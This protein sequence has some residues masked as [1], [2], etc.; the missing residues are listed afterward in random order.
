[1]D[2]KRLIKY[3]V[4]TF[5]ITWSCWWG[6]AFLL[7]ISPLTNLD[8]FP[9]VLFTL[10]GFGPTIAALLCM[11]GRLSRENIRS[12]LFHNTKRNW[13]VMFV[14]VAMETLAFSVCSIGMADM[15][16]KT[17]VAVM[18]IVIVFLQAAVLYG[19]NE[20][21]GWRGTMQPILKQAMPSPVATLLVGIVWICWHIPLWFIVGDS[22]QSM[23]FLSF[24]ILG[25]ALS[26][27]LSAIYDITGAVVF[28]M[29]L[30]GVTNTLMGVLKI[31][32]G[33]VYYVAI[34]VLTGISIA[35][36][37]YTQKKR[38]EKKV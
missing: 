22:H 10:G 37:I 21:L 28:C 1:M 19:G 6:E 9:M 3:L 14:A 16:P 33:T 35:A 18:V 30:H 34:S 5:L 32:Q 27:W 13:L 26:Y 36:S 2:K 11:N 7:F 15:I 29:I 25:I 17:P 4:I 24:A 8:V 23:S 38:S 12:F 20:E 31:N